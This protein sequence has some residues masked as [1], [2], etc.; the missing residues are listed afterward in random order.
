MSPI[1]TLPAILTIL[2]VFVAVYLLTTAAIT[3]LQR[4]LIY[5]PDRTR[6]VRYLSITCPG[7]ARNLA[8][9]DGCSVECWWLAP[10]HPNAPIV[11]YLQGNAGHIGYD[12]TP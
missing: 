7:V 8:V 9:E 1:Q 5:F 10:A 6:A 12:V 11:L 2:G 3:A 4:K